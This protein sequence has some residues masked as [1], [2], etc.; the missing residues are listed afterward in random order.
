M[1]DVMDALYTRLLL[2]DIF[3]KIIPGSALLSALYV[4]FYSLDE[5]KFAV[6]C[7][8]FIPGMAVAGISW[9]LAF[10]VQSVGEFRVY[11]KSLIRAYPKKYS[12]YSDW[13][14]Q[15][16]KFRNARLDERHYQQNERY[17]II[18][19][20]CGNTYVSIVLSTIILIL[21]HWYDQGLGAVAKIA[22]E[23]LHL[24]I[25]GLFLIIFLVRMRY[26][27]D[28]R[29]EKYL[30]VVLESQEGKNSGGNL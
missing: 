3:G 7:L 27:H 20:A 10:I 6:A 15:R 5:F 30:N 22:S 4:A 29:Q 12:S 11:G 13:A 28:D 8:T 21:D 9:I 2:R 1:K 18:R 24:I 14:K 17:G 26:K 23:N 16:V 25:V 19:E